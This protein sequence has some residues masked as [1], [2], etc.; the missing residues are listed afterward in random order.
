M[1]GA[2]GRGA[3][4]RDVMGR[5][6]QVPHEPQRLVSLVPSIGNPVQFWLGAAGG[7]ITEYCTNLR[8]GW[9]RRRGLAARKTP[10]SP[11]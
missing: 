5:L 4:L 8:L 9:L 2:W 6:V 3:R 7:G 10:I 11:R 1:G